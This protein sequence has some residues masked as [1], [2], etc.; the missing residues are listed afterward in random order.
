M[1]KEEEKIEIDGIMFNLSNPNI[2]QDY[3]TKEYFLKLSNGL[4]N[5][6]KLIMDLVLEQKHTAPRKQF[7]INDNNTKDYYGT[8]SGT[9]KHQTIDENIINPYLVKVVICTISGY[10]YIE[11]FPLDKKEFIKKHDLVL[12]IN[13]TDTYY[14][15]R[16]L[17][18]MDKPKPYRKFDNTYYKQDVKKLLLPNIDKNTKDIN[19]L[20]KNVL[21]RNLVMGVD[22]LTH[23]ILENK[24]YTFGVELETC[25]GRLEESDV[26]DLNVKAVHDGSL[27]DEAGN[28]PGGEYVTGILYG[29]S[30]FKQLHE[31]CKVLSNKCFINHQCGVHVHIGGMKWNK[32]DVVY[33]YLLAQHLEEDLFTMLPKSRRNNSYCRKLNPLLLDKFNYLSEAPSNSDYLL[34][35]EELYNA[36]HQEV[37]GTRDTEGPNAKINKNSNHPKG[38]KCGYDKTAQRY[39]WLNYVTL[40]FDTKGIPNSHTLEFRPHGATLNFAKIR[41]WIKIC[42]AF[43]YFVEN[44]KNI[45]K[46]GKYVHTNGTEYKLNL[47]L[48]IVKSYPKTAEKLIEY[49]RERK[50]IFKVKDESLDY[51]EDV[52]PISRSIKEVVCA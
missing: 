20:S 27:R 28:V 41:N 52:L 36:I 11:V 43:V 7:S 10:E 13:N 47:E 16:E 46:A 8:L 4:S 34:K 23:L 1:I 45:I 44:F 26:K 38:S 30:G 12:G 17:K 40:L 14:L 6:T 48:M 18:T 49:V 22:S 42:I 24:R 39:C 32:E 3:I 29:D 33:S 51:K 50:E 21:N 2:V 31:I 15:K 37:A 35:I 19:E 5:F 9:V 25:L